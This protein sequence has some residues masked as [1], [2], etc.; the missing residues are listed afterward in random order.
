MPNL[1]SRKTAPPNYAKKARLMEKSSA[2]IQRNLNKSVADEKQRIFRDKWLTRVT[3]DEMDLKSPT[4]RKKVLARSNDLGRVLAASRML[5]ENAIETKKNY[6]KNFR[7]NNRYEELSSLLNRRI[8]REKLF[9]AS[10]MGKETADTF[11]NRFETH[12]NRMLLALKNQEKK[13]N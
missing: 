9:L 10:L 8:N 11:F 7:F 6:A 3:L 2:R 5:E 12:T 1:K 13:R 4:L